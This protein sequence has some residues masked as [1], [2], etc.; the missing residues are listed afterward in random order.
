MELMNAFAETEVTLYRPGISHR[1][2]SS[3]LTRLYK[4]FK[5]SLFYL[6]LPL[7]R[8]AICYIDHKSAD[9]ECLL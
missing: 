5:S 4:Y 8:S 1:N 3:K 7:K 2:T 9:M 6:S